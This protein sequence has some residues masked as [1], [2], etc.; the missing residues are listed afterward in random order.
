MHQHAARM[1]HSEIQQLTKAT[2]ERLLKGIEDAQLP[3]EPEAQA[4]DISAWVPET[5]H[6]SEEKL[7]Q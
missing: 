1:H 7:R 5:G 4:L 3:M 6:I 2:Y